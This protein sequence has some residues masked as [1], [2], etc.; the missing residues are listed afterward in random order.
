MPDVETTPGIP[1]AELTDEDLDCELAH[2][3]EKR[4]DIFVG[5]TVE[6]LHNHNLRMSELER[7]Y[8]ARFPDRVM[9]ATAKSEL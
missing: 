8:L 3:H 7:A 9:D 4:H 6:Q 5:G 1:A 2:V